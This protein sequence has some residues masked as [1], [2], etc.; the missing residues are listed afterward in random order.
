MVTEEMYEI[1]IPIYIEKDWIT[2]EYNSFAKGYHAY[3]YMEFVGGRNVEM[4][5]RT[6]KGGGQKWNI[7]ILPDGKKLKNL[8]KYSPSSMLSV[9]RSAACGGHSILHS[10]FLTCVRIADTAVNMIYSSKVIF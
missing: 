4:Q 6:V 9:F 10:I 3:E 8:E 1:Y 2:C 7:E 5:A